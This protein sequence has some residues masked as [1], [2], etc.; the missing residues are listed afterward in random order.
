MVIGFIK[1][2][3]HK[4]IK[5]WAI[6]TVSCPLLLILL[7]FLKTGLLLFHFI[8]IY[9]YITCRYIYVCREREKEKERGEVFF[10]L[11]LQWNYWKKLWSP[12]L[13]YWFWLFPPFPVSSYHSCPWNMLK[14]PLFHGPVSVSL[15][16]FLKIAQNF[17]HAHPSTAKFRSIFLTVAYLTL[18]SCSKMYE[19][20][21]CHVGSLLHWQHIGEEM[22]HGDDKYLLIHLIRSKEYAARNK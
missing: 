2:F 5:C 18:S 16:F 9:I 3:L 7:F 6:F 13:P 10:K 20:R 12:L 15:F 21:I 22:T 17:S 4:C 1:T 8:Y 11:R 14:K 19:G